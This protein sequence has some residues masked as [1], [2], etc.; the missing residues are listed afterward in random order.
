MFVQSTSYILQELFLL[1]LV[2]EYN[3]QTWRIS[4]YKDIILSL[5][6]IELSPFYDF[7][8]N[9]C[10]EHIIHTYFK[11]YSKDTL[12]ADTGMTWRSAQET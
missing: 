10:Q 12:Y 3:R 9:I 8:I 2:Y 11:R 6:T 5:L 7:C 4:M 1:N